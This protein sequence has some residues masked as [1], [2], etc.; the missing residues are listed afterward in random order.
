MNSKYKQRQNKVVYTHCKNMNRYNLE[1]K[2]KLTAYILLFTLGGLGIHRLYVEDGHMFLAY[3]VLFL[4]SVSFFIPIGIVMLFTM[5]IY[6]IFRIGCKVE[7]YNDKLRERY[8]G[9]DVEV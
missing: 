4:I 7:I 6:D 9:T 2:H 8:F 3:L 1:K 5:V